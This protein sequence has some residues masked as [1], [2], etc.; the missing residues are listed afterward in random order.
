MLWACLPAVSL[1]SLPSLLSLGIVPDLVAGRGPAVDLCRSFD[2]YEQD[3]GN[4]M[5]SSFPYC[6]WYANNVR[7][8]YIRRPLFL[9]LRK[10]PLTFLVWIFLYALQ[11]PP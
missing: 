7:A 1:P 6:E 3:S 5:N 2:K 11:W 8:L 10:D 9:P 4:T